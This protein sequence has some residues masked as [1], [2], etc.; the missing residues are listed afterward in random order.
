MLA[1]TVNVPHALSARAPTTTMPRPAIAMTMIARIAT[2]ATIPGSTPSS[3][4]T[5]SASERPPRRME[6]VRMTKSCTA[7]ASTTPASSQRKPGAKPNCAASVGP[8]SGPE[9]LIAAKWCPKSTHLPVG[10]KLWPS[11]RRCAGVT[12]A[13]SSTSAFAARNAE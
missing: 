13:S 10:T 12:R 5:S 6:A 11:R 9:P 8:M 4:R 2:I 3:S 7:P 1:P